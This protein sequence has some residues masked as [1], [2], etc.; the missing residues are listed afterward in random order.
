MEVKLIE[1][2]AVQLN[3]HFQLKRLSGVRAVLE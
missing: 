2:Y 3:R 1:H